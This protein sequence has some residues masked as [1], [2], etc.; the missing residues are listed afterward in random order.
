MMNMEAKNQY[1]SVLRK[2]YLRLKTKKE[3]TIWQ[4]DNQSFG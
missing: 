4:R 3:K 1:L 2:E